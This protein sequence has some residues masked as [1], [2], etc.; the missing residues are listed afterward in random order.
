[1]DRTYDVSLRRLFR[2]K[3]LFFCEFLNFCHGSLLGGSK[4]AAVLIDEGVAGCASIIGVK[5]CGL[6]LG[7][8]DGEPRELS[9]FGPIDSVFG[10]LVLADVDE[11]NFGISG[12]VL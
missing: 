3:E 4:D 8:G 5:P 10:I 7:R 1:M 6:D 2:E 11:L 9:A 12:D